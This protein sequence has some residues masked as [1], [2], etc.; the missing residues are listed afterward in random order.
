[1][2]DITEHYREMRH[3][4]LGEIPKSQKWSKVVANIVH[5]GHGI[6]SVGT[7]LV[8]VETIAND[9]LDAAEFGLSRSIDD[10]G[11][12]YTFYLL[13]QITLA[14]REDDWKEYLADIG[15]TLADDSSLFELTAELQ[16]AIDSHVWD[17][18]GATDVS[19]MAQQAA[20]E[21][22]SRL[23]GP[24]AR[25]LFGSGS[26]E[27]QDAVRKLSTKSGFSRLGQ[28][29]FGGFMARFLNF[30]LSRITTGQVGGDSL[31]QVSALS[32]FN[33]L[34][35]AHCKQS[36]QIVRSFCGEWYSKT[37][38]QKGINL[39]NTSGFMAIA[40]RKLQSELSKQKEGQ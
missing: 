2:N 27:L 36:A 3:Q 1:M 34:L 11:L 22:I 14:S 40:M 23:A 35:D 31:R 21:A 15:I 10:P 25:T 24:N 16:D 9:T 38:F 17:H 6:G 28:E 8:N 30:Y 12:Q 33:D 20:G 26:A 5:G 32:Q 4:R 37:E 19:E 13:T 18:G 7:L 39:Q 29:F